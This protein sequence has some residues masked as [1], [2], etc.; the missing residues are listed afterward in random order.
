MLITVDLNELRWSTQI[1]AEAVR[2]SL[3]RSGRPGRQREPDLGVR[4]QSRSHLPV[5]ILGNLDDGYCPSH[6]ALHCTEAGRQHAIS[7]LSG[8][9]RRLTLFKAEVR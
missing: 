5:R 1:E 8:E 2:V 7:T 3:S 4:L 6:V 9:G